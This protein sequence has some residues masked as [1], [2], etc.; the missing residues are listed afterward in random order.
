MRPGCRWSSTG[1][2]TAYLTAVVAYI[3]FAKGSFA[4]WMKEHACPLLKKKR[5]DEV[6]EL[7][8]YLV[9]INTNIFHVLEI[10][11]HPLASTLIRPCLG[12]RGS[13]NGNRFRRETSKRLRERL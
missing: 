11:D 6:L 5:R 2:R 12:I 7:A 10:I 13:A 4:S 9:A 8:S 3:A 1:G